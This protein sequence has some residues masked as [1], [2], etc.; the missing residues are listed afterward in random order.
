MKFRTDKLYDV[1]QEVITLWN[2]LHNAY[3][4]TIF[5]DSAT[6]GE[7]SDT[8]EWQDD[9]K[10][11]QLFLD[12]VLR[13][14]SVPSIVLREKSDGTR[15]ILDGRRRI[16]II[17]NFL[18]GKTQIPYSL[19]DAPQYQSFV[20]YKFINIPLG[21]RDY[22]HTKLT[23]NADVIKGID[24]EQVARK[25]FFELHQGRDKET[26]TTLCSAQN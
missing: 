4:D 25:L 6:Q 12:A 17:R 3:P 11:S 15:E 24:D 23:I 1:I 26:E 2:F 14:S 9:P 16:N 19:A 18:R 8:R 21:I 5:Y 20:G 13:R 22:V 10:Q 7:N